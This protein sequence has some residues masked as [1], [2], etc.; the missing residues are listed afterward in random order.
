[1]IPTPRFWLVGDR[2][3]P[4]SVR[5]AAGFMFAGACVTV[6]QSLA[7]IALFAR[8][9]KA[10]GYGIGSVLQCVLFV[11]LWLLVARTTQQ[12]KS[13]GR[14]VGTV[15]FAYNT[16]TMVVFVTQ[17][18]SADAT[19]IFLFTVDVLMWTAGL[20]AVVYL[21]M[22]DSASHFANGRDADGPGGSPL[23]LLKAAR[24]KTTR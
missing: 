18:I 15:L 17:G 9:D 12:G 13:W 23:K 24:T 5:R 21:W 2:D 16:L 8:G 4:E 19:G 6:F 20:G 3:L 11:G 7:A 22:R 14:T 1:M 10:L